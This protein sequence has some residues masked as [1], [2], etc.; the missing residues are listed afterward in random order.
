M[1]SILLSNIDSYFHWISTFSLAVRRKNLL[2][3]FKN[4]FFS[5]G[6]CL[7]K[8]ALKLRVKAIVRWNYTK[9]VDKTERRRRKK[10]SMERTEGKDCRAKFSTV[11]GKISIEARNEW[12]RQWRT[13]TCDRINSDPTFE[14]SRNDDRG[15]VLRELENRSHY[16]S[17]ESPRFL[18]KT[19]FPRVALKW[20]R[21]LWLWRDY[22]RTASIRLRKVLSFYRKIEITL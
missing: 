16:L 7:V 20:W 13:L 5:G 8:S 15:K 6:V 21:P 22:S 18:G 9:S 2:W 12:F 4:V 14:N 1:I 17:V 10:L 19:S 11:I 3:L